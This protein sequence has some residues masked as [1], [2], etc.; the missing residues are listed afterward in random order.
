[1]KGD[2]RVRHALRMGMIHNDDAPESKQRA[3]TSPWTYIKPPA[4][5]RVPYTAE[6]W[7]A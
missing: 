6:S 1:M 7:A 5:V 4:E 3:R 2:G